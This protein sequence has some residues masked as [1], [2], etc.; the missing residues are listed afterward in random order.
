MVSMNIKNLINIKEE[1]INEDIF[2]VK[3]VF[4]SFVIWDVHNLI[5]KVE[6]YLYGI[7]YRTDAYEHNDIVYG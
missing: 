3:M 2:K 7:D 4:K 1:I 6:I 5:I